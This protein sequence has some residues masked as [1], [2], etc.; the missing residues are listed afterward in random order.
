MTNFE[1]ITKSPEVL[2][3]ELREN[4][5]LCDYCFA[6]DQC[7]MVP[8]VDCREEILNWLKQEAEE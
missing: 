3:D 1:R 7:P 2:A 5:T 8:G 4:V 6:K